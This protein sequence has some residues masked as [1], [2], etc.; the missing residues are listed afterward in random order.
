MLFVVVHL[1]IFSSIFSPTALHSIIDSKPLSPSSNV[2]VD[3][4][5]SMAASL[6]AHSRQFHSSW[7]DYCILYLMVVVNGLLALTCCGLV[8]FC[9][10]RRIL[11]R[12]QR[13]PAPPRGT[14]T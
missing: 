13:A 11:V 3:I 14:V 8:F 4:V 10:Y 9:F 2:H 5:N 7:R 12:L 1:L 6:Q